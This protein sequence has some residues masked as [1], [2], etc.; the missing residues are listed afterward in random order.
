MASRMV[1]AGDCRPARACSAVFRHLTAVAA[2]TALVAGCGRRGPDVQYVEGV[3]TLQGRRLAGATVCF[4]PVGVGLPGAGQTDA[5]GRYTLTTPNG[6]PAAGVTV[7]EFTVTV[8]KYEDWRDEF[9]PPPQA[10]DAQGFA[11]W[12]EE[13][14]EIVAKR[15]QQKPKLL[16][17]VLYS[18]AATTPLKAWVKRGKN[19]GPEFSFELR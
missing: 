3:V 10:S 19:T 16:T 12:N 7:G 17:P 18:Q 8:E 1:P 2:C 11:R 6:R 15:A 5:E 14:K 4:Y 13:M 9:P